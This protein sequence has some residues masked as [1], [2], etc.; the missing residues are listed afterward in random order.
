MTNIYWNYI[1]EVKRISFFKFPTSATNSCV[2]NQNTYIK[3]FK[4]FR[5]KIVFLNFLHFWKVSLDSKSINF[6]L[7]LYNFKAF[8]DFLK[9]SWNNTNVKSLLGKIM[10][11]SK[12]NSIWT[13]CNN[14][15]CVTIFVIDVWNS[16][17]RVNLWPNKVVV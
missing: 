15:P 6:V 5:N 4:F 17:S 16:K 2:D 12:S 7:F 1:L 8:I 9:I 13:T 10:A 3:I 11:Q 14:S